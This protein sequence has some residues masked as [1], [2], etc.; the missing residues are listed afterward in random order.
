MTPVRYTS[1]DGLEIPAYLTV[2][3]GTSGEEHAG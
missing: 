2:P 1:S 3:K